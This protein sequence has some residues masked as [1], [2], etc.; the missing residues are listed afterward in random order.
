[1]KNVE[2]RNPP[3]LTSSP[4]V[5]AFDEV[6]VTIFPVPDHA[7]IVVCVVVVAVVTLNVGGAPG[8]TWEIRSSVYA[9]ETDDGG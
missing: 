7:V 6:N 8:P 2:V 3:S 1:L 5:K 4:A 9:P